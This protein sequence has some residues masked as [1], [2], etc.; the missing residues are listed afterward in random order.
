MLKRLLPFWPL[1]IAIVLLGTFFLTQGTSRSLSLREDRI[2][3]SPQTEA[4]IEKLQQQLSQDQPSQ[5]RQRTLIALSYAYLQNIRETAD[6]SLYGDIET[7]MQQAEAIDAKD[8]DIWLVRAAVSAGK[9]HFAETLA[10]AERAVQL[11][12]RSARSYGIL[13]DAQVELGQYEQAVA[14][15]QTM[16]DLRPDFSAYS[17]IAHVRE[18]YG[19]REGA[20]E[21]MNM[22]IDAGGAFPE[23]SAWAEV[24]LGKLSMPDQL[25]TAEQHFQRALSIVPD[26]PRAVQGL[27]KVAFA[28]EQW[29]KALEHFTRAYTLLP[30]A[31]HA[32]DLGDMYFLRGEELKA[33]QLFALA[34][35]AFRESE[36]T[37]TNID[38]EYAMFLLDH[39]MQPALALEKAKSA[40]TNQPS[41]DGADTLAW[42]LYNNDR[43]AE[44]QTYVPQT[45]RLGTPSAAIHYHAGLIALA[46]GNR[47]DARKFL[48]KARTLN[49]YFSLLHAKKLQ[50]T[51]S[52]L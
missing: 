29:D 1:L 42:A 23:N 25:T 6:T 10:F 15:V 21:A 36:R 50:D 31:E 37:G 47:V 35:A 46:N 48:E 34:D 17:R 30:V 8:P 19:D 22:A 32:I 38:L 41:I 9:H 45:L 39:D 12:P 3:S 13:A 18:L 52:R 2:L 14:T 16:V 40:Y 51:L 4:A 43:S 5:E 26:Y 27:G 33:T 7:L 49:P 20:I 28:R 44:A 11:N 24:E